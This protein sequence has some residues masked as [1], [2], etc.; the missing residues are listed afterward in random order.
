MSVSDR[1]VVVR[2]P[3]ATD[4]GGVVLAEAVAGDGDVDITRW[5]S[6]VEVLRIHII[7]R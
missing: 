7:S 2:I 4:G 3:L 6:G 1:L 5:W